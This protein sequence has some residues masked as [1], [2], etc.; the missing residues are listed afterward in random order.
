MVPSQ[1]RIILGNINNHKASLTPHDSVVINNITLLG[2][3]AAMEEAADIITTTMEAGRPNTTTGRH[4]IHSEEDMYSSN[5]MV[6][7]ENAAPGIKRIYVDEPLIP[8]CSTGISNKLSAITRRRAA[9][10]ECPLFH[11]SHLSISNKATRTADKA[12]A[13]TLGLPIYLLRLFRVARLLFKRF[14]KLQSTFLP[15]S[16]RRDTILSNL[17]F[18]QHLRDI[19]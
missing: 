18:D 11:P 4:P 16:P 3:E 19:S 9:E 15:S 10:A 1:R 5:S 13:S 6:N 17:T 2:P 7:K 8:T 14:W 12:L